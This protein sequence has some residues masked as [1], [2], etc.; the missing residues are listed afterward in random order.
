M[1]AH[2]LLLN[3]KHYRTLLTTMFNGANRVLFRQSTCCLCTAFLLLLIFSLLYVYAFWVRFRIDVI[4]SNAYISVIRITKVIAL[5]Q[6]FLLP[7]A[8]HY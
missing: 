3:K 5:E 8:C 6:M 2:V 7:S 1:S 4:S